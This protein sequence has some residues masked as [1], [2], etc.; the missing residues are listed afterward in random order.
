MTQHEDA[1]TQEA[2]TVAFDYLMEGLPV[3]WYD[4]YS[5]YEGVYHDTPDMIAIRLKAEEYMT[6]L[7]K[8][9]QERRNT[10]SESI[11]D[12]ANRIIHGARRQQY[13]GV[14]ESFQLIA[15]LWN[16][17]L[18]GLPASTHLSAPDIAGMM[19]LLKVA[20]SIN[21]WHRDSYV[22][23]AGYAALT[24]QLYTGEQTGEV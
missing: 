15:D 3:N 8:T 6:D 23:I 18:K 13:G 12:E 2:F 11:L 14:Q 10:S 16:G 4:C 20:R 7:A 17:Y 19:I 5:K 21:G 1:I 24:E 9:L 22:D